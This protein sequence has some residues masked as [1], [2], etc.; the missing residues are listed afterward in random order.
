MGNGGVGRV[1]SWIEA[2]IAVMSVA[3]IHLVW[4]VSRLARDVPFE[5]RRR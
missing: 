4:R 3:Y 2:G 1:T 5:G